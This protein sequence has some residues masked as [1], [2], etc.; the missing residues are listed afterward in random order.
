M[1]MLIINVDNIWKSSWKTPLKDR[2]L[3]SPSSLT[4]FTIKS[5]VVYVI[6]QNG[7]YIQIGL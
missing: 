5:L 7:Y 3:I 4:T 6:V 2:G 1:S